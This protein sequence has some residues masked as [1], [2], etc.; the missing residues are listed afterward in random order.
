MDENIERPFQSPTESMISDLLRSR[1]REA[2]NEPESH[3]NVLS[4][5]T[6]YGDTDMNP[7]ADDQKD[8]HQAEPDEHF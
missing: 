4:E 5:Q 1:Q 2:G 8:A 7:Q 3:K 6:V